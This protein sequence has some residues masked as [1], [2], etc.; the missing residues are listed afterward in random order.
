MYVIARHIHGIILN[1]KEYALDDN[2]EVKKFETP[3]KAMEFLAIK[4]PDLRGVPID[5]LADDYG[6]FIELERGS[7]DGQI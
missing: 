3:E 7:D 1:P 4:E 5:D 2:G 6:V